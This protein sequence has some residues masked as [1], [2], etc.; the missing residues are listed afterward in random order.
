M[1]RRT[2]LVLCLVLSA[3]PAP[4]VFA[5]GP[6]MS[7]LWPNDDGRSWRYQSRF[8]EFIP[9]PTLNDQLVRLIL[10]GGTIAPV[11][12]ATQLLRE[13][14]PSGPIMTFAAAPDVSNPFL[15][16]LWNA[17]PDLRTAISQRALASL[18][19]GSACPADAPPGG[20]PAFFLSGEKAFLKTASEIGSWRCNA[21][22]TQQW[23][24][25][26]SDLTPG[27]TFSLQLVPDL[28]SDVILHG[29]VGTLEDV[30][31]PAGTYSC[32]RVDYVVDY[33]ISV[34]VD[35]NG[36]PHGTFRS[37]TRG[38]VHYASGVGPIQSLEEFIQFAEVTG[39][40][41]PPEDVGLVYSRVTRQLDSSPVLVVATSWG[42]IKTIY[43]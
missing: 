39:D 18:A 30:T 29:T 43:R 10:D 11:G 1:L 5:G 8:E 35:V 16:N 40:C 19:G 41:A 34:C 15:R 9:T 28:A 32:L 42:R 20:Q 2:T 26:V 3:A 36:T 37:E 33:G 4:R 6:T 13:E 21:D 38:F 25:L 14:L 24:W 17:R 27:N 22:N 12:I 7:E 23:L 31:V